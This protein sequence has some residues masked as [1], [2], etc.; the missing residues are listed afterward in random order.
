MLKYEAYHFGENNI[1]CYYNPHSLN[2]SKHLHRSFEFIYVTCGN[3]EVSI[4]NKTFEVP[5]NSC[6]LILPYEVHSI[7]TKNILMRIFAYFH[8]SI[9]IFFKV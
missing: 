3:I 2:Y 8:L 7:K 1:F 4:D 6:I 9:L 5:K